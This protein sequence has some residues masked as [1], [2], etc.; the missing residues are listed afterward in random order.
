[1]RFH[2]DEMSKVKTHLFPHSVIESAQILIFFCLVGMSKLLVFSSKYFL[3]FL[4]SKV[5]KVGA[6]VRLC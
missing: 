5:R 4:C 2:S 1:M 6:L 3:P